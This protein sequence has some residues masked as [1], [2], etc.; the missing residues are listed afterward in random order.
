MLP[1]TA[2]LRT[3]GRAT[4]LGVAELVGSAVEEASVGI[5]LLDLGLQALPAAKSTVPEM[6]RAANASTERIMNE[7]NNGA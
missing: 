7:C 3:F 2:K 4:S 1:L 5:V 6:A